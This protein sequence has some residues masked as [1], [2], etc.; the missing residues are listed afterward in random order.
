MFSV[1]HSFSWRDCA[2]LS[3]REPGRRNTQL[4]GPLRAGLRRRWACARVALPLPGAALLPPPPIRPHAAENLTG[5]CPPRG[6]A[7]RRFGRR[8]GAREPPVDTAAG[9]PGGQLLTGRAA[10]TRKPEPRR[11]RSRARRRREV[12]GAGSRAAPLAPPPAGAMDAG[13]DAGAPGTLRALPARSPRPEGRDA[14]PRGPVGPALGHHPQNPG[15]EAAWEVQAVLALP[16]PALRTPRGR[17]RKGWPLAWPRG[18]CSP[19]SPPGVGSRGSSGGSLGA[20]STPLL[21]APSFPR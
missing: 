18:P 6:W 16:P 19:T 12:P 13:E 7:A 9:S 17:V 20:L 4:R 21:H 15:Q 3:P 8:R 14:L 5:T 11:K 2:T 1:P 10:G